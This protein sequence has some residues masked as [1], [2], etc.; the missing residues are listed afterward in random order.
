MA[1][2]N[3]GSL[4]NIVRMVDAYFSRLGDRTRQWQ[5]YENAEFRLVIDVGRLCWIDVNPAELEDYQRKHRSIVERWREM[6]PVL[7]VSRLDA[8]AQAAA[9]AY[10]RKL[11]LIV[12]VVR[13]DD[14]EETMFG[15]VNRHEWR[16]RKG[17]RLK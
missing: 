15:P 2:E 7:D 9:L 16:D 3:D 4:D 6:K 5:A 13:P 8:A 11:G 1:N 12:D 17:I 14:I 10:A